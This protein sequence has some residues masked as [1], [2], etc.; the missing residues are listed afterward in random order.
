MKHGKT[1]RRRAGR[2]GGKQGERN[3]QAILDA[4]REHFSRHGF[5]A[6]T[7]R[8]IAA[9]ADVTPAM[10]HYHFG[11]KAGLYF[12]VIESVAEPL[13]A[14][15]GQI[16]DGA[17]PGDALAAFMDFYM[18]TVSRHP[19]IPSL[20]LHDVLGEDGDMRSGFATRFASRGRQAISGLLR[21]AQ[22]QGRIPR[23]L[24]IDL[25]VISILSLALFPFLAA[26]LIREVFGREWQA[27][28]LEALIRHQQ[29]VLLHGLTCKEDTQ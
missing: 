27:D 16:R 25:G 21:N 19:E 14:R 3:R 28:E 8:D 12:A 1:T 24:D 7:L 9:S 2:Q 26:P 23:E 15:L 22:E 18:R 29:A 10:V 20:L 4:A 11:N 17:Q 13:L 5:R 6:T